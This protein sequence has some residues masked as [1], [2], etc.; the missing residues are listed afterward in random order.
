MEK[1]LKLF[2]AALVAIL[3]V[4]AGA[5]EIISHRRT[6]VRVGAD[7][8]VGD[9]RFRVEVRRGDHYEPHRTEHG[10][11]IELGREY[12]PYRR[13]Y[14][15]GYYPPERHLLRAP[16]T[17]GYAG[18]DRREVVVP[19]PTAPRTRVEETREQEAPRYKMKAG[20]V[21]LTNETSCL[22][23]VANSRTG[24]YILLEPGAGTTTF[25]KVRDLVAETLDR[26]DRTYGPAQIVPREDVS[27]EAYKIV[28]TN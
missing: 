3:C 6:D 25:W 12:R 2:A 1:M 16:V 19:Q 22:V 26:S 27:Y 24:E 4:P 9:A 28:V 10:R 13:D 15:R 23:T 5:Q 7:V 17:F 11:R 18:D 8:R 14:G 20:E 21:F